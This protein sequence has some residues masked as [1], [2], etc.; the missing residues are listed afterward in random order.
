[1]RAQDL[2][3]ALLTCLVYAAF[4]GWTAWAWRRQQQAAQQRAQALLPAAPGQ[5]VWWVCHASQTGQAEGIATQTAQL[6][7][8]AGVPVRLQSLGQLTAADLQQGQRLLCVVSTYGEGDPPVSAMPFMQRL[9]TDAALDL[10]RL[11]VGVLALGDRSYAQFCG[12]GRALAQWLGERG[13]QPLFE[14]IEVDRS[15]TAALQQWRL[16]LARLAGTSDLPDWQAPA[17]ERWQLQ[18]RRHLNAGSQGEPVH[19]LEL[20]PAPGQL[21]PD[22]QAGDLVQLEVP[23]A[24]GAPRDYSIASVPADGAL[25]LLVRR[26]RRA[27]GSPGLASAWLT[28]GLEEGGELQL[29]LRAHTGF[30]IE[31]N[32]ARP[33]ILIGNGTGLAG[34]RA[35]MRGRLAAAGH[36]ADADRVPRPASVAPMWLLFGERQAQH[37]A[38]YREEIEA[39][40][41]QGW[42]S[43]LDWVFSRDQAERRYVQHALRDAAGRL[44][45]LVQ[46]GAAIYVCGSLVGMAGE[47]DHTLGEILGEAQLQQLLAEGRYRRDVY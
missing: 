11:H 7:H 32:D 4:C 26:T 27:D 23:G 20:R 19:H 40:A 47:V 38:Y 17:Y 5:D 45:V 43:Q 44:R 2:G 35:H 24:A 28:Q 41:Q 22:W 14:R 18:A 46:G 36:L 10:S 29:R 8:Q 12:F 21:L 42:L 1:M 31:G 9:M 13:A 25:H 33:L 6:L 30:R 34:L 3:Y 16:Q 15:D 37:D 39:W